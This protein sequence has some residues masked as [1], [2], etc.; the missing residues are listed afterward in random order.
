M[1]EVLLKIIKKPTFLTIVSGVSVYVIGQ[2]I[3]ETVIKPRKKLKELKGQIIF[4]LTLYANLLANPY[5]NKRKSDDE[6]RN[7]YENAAKEIRKTASELSGHLGA[8][9][10][11]CNKNRYFDVINNLIGLSNGLFETSP[12]IN[13]IKEN[14][15]CVNSINKT[16]K[17]K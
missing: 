1:Y 16:L 6:I 8:Y 7:N 13:T 3:L 4:I 12:E 5:N 11:I 17:I 10:I 14:R 2:I 9:P 15:K